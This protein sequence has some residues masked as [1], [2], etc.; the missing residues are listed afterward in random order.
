MNEFI[1]KDLL[2]DC[3]INTERLA[4]LSLLDI[5]TEIFSIQFSDDIDMDDYFE[6]QEELNEEEEELNNEIEDCSVVKVEVGFGYGELDGDSDLKELMCAEQCKELAKILYNTI[7]NS[8]YFYFYDDMGMCPGNSYGC[9][10]YIDEKNLDEIVHTINSFLKD[11]YNII[12]L[13][14]ENYFR[15]NYIVGKVLDKVRLINTNTQTR[16]IPLLGKILKEI[17]I[18]LR[19][20]SIIKLR[21]H[22][23]S[24]IQFEKDVKYRNST[25]ILHR[26]DSKKNIVETTAFEHYITLLDSLGLITKVNDFVRCTKFGTL[27]LKLLETQDKKEN[28]DCEVTKIFFQYWFLNYDADGLLAVIQTIRG[29]FDW[30]ISASNIFQ[31]DKTGTDSYLRS[32]IDSILEYRFI[33]K[34]RYS[35]STTK[36]S[37]EKKLS[38][39]KKETIINKRKNI[40]FSAPAKHFI[41]PRLAW[42]VYWNLIVLDKKKYTLTKSGLFFYE[43]LPK[44]PIS[45][46]KDISDRWLQN[47]LFRLLPKINNIE[48]IDFDK[49]KVEEQDKKL[50][51]LL[52]ELYEWQNDGALR[53]SYYTT[54]LYICFRCLFDNITVTFLMLNEKFKDGFT[55]NNKSFYLKLSPRLNESYITITIH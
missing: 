35:N 46:T 27:Y 10:A 36:L 20:L 32:N 33:E 34:S 23:W 25:G 44:L 28:Y 54:Y 8:N 39:I 53:L 4:S 31:V 41:P 51:V 3:L 29:D 6:K 30:F 17:S 45:T 15:N 52:S 47:R 38:E 50:Y 26:Y 40:K 21:V 37:I 22:N 7:S 19:P 12:D 9:Y 24:K 43:S 55:F 5:D 2:L 11:A 48:T 42:L 14:S 1:N 16:Y 18:E 49:L 13:F